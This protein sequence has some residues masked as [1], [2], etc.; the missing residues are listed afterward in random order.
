[1]IDN[2]LTQFDGGMKK[3]KHLLRVDSQ[4]IRGYL[5]YDC[6]HEKIGMVSEIYCDRYDLQP[7]FIEITPL[8]DR[9]EQI[10][11]YPIECACWQS[12]G[13]VFIEST[14]KSLSTYETYDLGYTLATHGKQLITYNESLDNTINL[15][16]YEGRM[17][18]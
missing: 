7:R 14:Q 13:P 15:I 11:S 5:V 3:K 9:C 6:N 12:G 18:A 10:F 4:D 1:M 8:D 2:S 17:C 16:T